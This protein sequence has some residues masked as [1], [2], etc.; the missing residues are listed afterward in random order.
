M[1]R[2]NEEKEIKLCQIF[3]NDRTHH[4][5]NPKMGMKIGGGPYNRW[6]DKCE[7]YQDRLDFSE[8]YEEQKRN[9]KENLLSRVEIN[10]DD[11]QD[12]KDGTYEGIIDTVI[13]IS[14]NNGGNFE[15]D[16][17]FN[18]IVGKNIIVEIPEN[19]TSRQTG[20]SIITFNDNRGIT[21]GKLL[22]QLLPY[23]RSNYNDYHYFKGLQHVKGN[24][25]RLI[26]SYDSW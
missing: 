2:V 8:I 1:S 4:P 21:N 19:Y 9:N 24:T 16:T 18:E 17:Y 14:N 22:L 7:K 15:D 10:V 20:N 11:A 26:L 12:I 6:V 5:D 23:I 25:Y 3:L 13:Q